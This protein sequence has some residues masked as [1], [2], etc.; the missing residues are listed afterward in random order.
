MKRKG[1]VECTQNKHTVFIENFD[2]NLQ[3]VEYKLLRYNIRS[4]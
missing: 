2:F 3:K 4:L 1:E